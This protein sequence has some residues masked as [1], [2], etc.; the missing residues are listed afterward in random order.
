MKTTYID[1]KPETQWAMEQVTR[2]FGFKTL[3]EVKAALQYDEDGI[4]VISK[5][6]MR[7]I[8]TTNRKAWATVKIAWQG[9]GMQKEAALEYSQRY[10]KERAA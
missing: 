5:N 4:A 10:L 9:V 3:A 6:G 7:L 1:G 8:G 2:I